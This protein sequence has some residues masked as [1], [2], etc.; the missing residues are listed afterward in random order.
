MIG[1]VIYVVSVARHTG[2]SVLIGYWCLKK[3]PVY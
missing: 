2:N 1:S 3:T